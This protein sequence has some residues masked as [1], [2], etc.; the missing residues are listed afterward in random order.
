[1][2]I[3]TVTFLDK[4]RVAYYTSTAFNYSK[5]EDREAKKA[6]KHFCEK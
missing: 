2:F 4:P 3:S 5:K 1:M 6:A